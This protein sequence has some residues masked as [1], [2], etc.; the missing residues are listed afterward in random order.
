M[1]T[2]LFDY[3]GSYLTIHYLLLAKEL[4]GGAVASSTTHWRFKFNPYL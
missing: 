3:L 4:H 1:T 2:K